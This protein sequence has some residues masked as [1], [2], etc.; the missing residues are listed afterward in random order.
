MLFKRQSRKEWAR[1]GAF[2]TGT[3]QSNLW[4]INTKMKLYRYVIL[5]VCEG[6]LM[7]AADAS[8]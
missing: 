7:T 8:Q 2:A 3:V 5:Q 1:L 6:M 4:G